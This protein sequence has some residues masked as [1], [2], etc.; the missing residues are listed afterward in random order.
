MS[1]HVGYPKEMA[2]RCENK[3][4][5]TRCV[6]TPELS[7]VLGCTLEAAYRVHFLSHILLG[8]N[9]SFAGIL[10]P[11]RTLCSPE[12]NRQQNRVDTLYAAGPST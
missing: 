7:E 11:L 5:D 10:L 8:P 12:I 9:N 4:G 2:G 6:V 1:L 3:P